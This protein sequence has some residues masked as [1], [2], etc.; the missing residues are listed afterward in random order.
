M[1]NLVI[2]VKCRLILCD[3]SKIKFIG[4]NTEIFALNSLPLTMFFTTNRE[5][6]LSQEVLDVYCFY[7]EL[8][9]SGCGS[10][11]G[12]KYLTFNGFLL[13]NSIE[14][15][16]ETKKIEFLDFELRIQDYSLEK[17]YKIDKNKETT[18]FEIVKTANLSEKIMILPDFINSARVL[19]QKRLKAILSRITILEGKIK[20]LLEFL[21]HLKTT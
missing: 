7:F 16:L 5:P 2:C 8:F 10:Q 13:Q 15:S 21:S 9:C 20:E 4:E 19:E 6:I 11:I 18:L 3:F 14:N 12:R 17:D 1:F